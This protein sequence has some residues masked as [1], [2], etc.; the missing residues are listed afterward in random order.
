MQE[1]PSVKPAGLVFSALLAAVL[2][3]T[4][5]CTDPSPV[6]VS[7][8]TPT[9]RQ[10]GGAKPPPPPPPPPST[11]SGLFFCPQT[12]DSVT[13]VIGPRGGALVVGPH[14]LWVDS[15]VLRD[16]VRIT[17][18]APKDTVR[19][20]RFSPDNLLFPPNGVDAWKAGALLYTNYKDCGTIPTGTLRIA[21]VDSSLKILRYLESV[22][23]GKKNSWSRGDQYIYG[24]LPH[25][26]G[27]AVAY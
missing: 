23:S 24:W 22:S 21:Q 10:S 19:T 2:V 13:Q 6:G 27:Y 16:T 1:G 25:F 14:L 17:A 20:V 18:V 15:L 11:T 9:F 4:V 7:L 8:G 5:G 26:S 3:A 12:Y